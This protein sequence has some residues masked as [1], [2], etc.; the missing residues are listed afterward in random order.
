MK[1]T[2]PSIFIGSSVEGLDVAYSLQQ[3]LEYDSEPTVWSQGIFNPTQAAITD[4]LA[5]TRH[6][7]FALFVF[8]ADDV[9]IMRDSKASVP[10][11]NVVFE[12][13]LFIGGI[14]V[15]RCFFVMPRDEEPLQLPSDLLG[16]TPIT[17]NAGRSDGRLLAALGPAVHQVRSQLRR[18]GKRP[19]RGIFA[20][21]AA[22]VAS[23]TAPDFISQWDSPDLL[24]ARELL[25]GGVP[26]HAYEDE[27]GA[28]TRAVRRVFAF[29]DS[30][31][32]ALLAGLV[33][34]ALARKVFDQPVRSV[35]EHARFYL[36]PL[37]AADEV[38]DPPPPLALLYNRW[39]D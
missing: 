11:D 35:W 39:K 33:D 29:L 13:G 23:A 37:N 21:D 30:M 25:R 10:R 16:L 34:E 24:R 4:L 12:L 28:T 5:E 9:R 8:S 27:T 32:D 20:M 1:P 36:A 26:A 7:D 31:A 2:L 19:A 14:G 18:L 17:Y 15:D 22:P 6:S 38:W 3:S